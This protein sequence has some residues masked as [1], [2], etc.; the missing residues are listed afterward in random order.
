MAGHAR[1][2]N[3]FTEDEKYQNLMSWSILTFLQS[4]SPPCSHIISNYRKNSKISDTL[5]FA[6]ITLKVEQDGFFFKP[7]HPKDAKGIANSVDP[8]LHVGTV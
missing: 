5:K 6:V 2:K 3:K 1:L 4:R 8:D 7:M